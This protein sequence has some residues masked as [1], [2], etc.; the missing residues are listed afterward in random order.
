MLLVVFSSKFRWLDL[1]ESASQYECGAEQIHLKISTA[2]FA[3][4]FRL[5]AIFLVFELELV[6]L[7]LALPLITALDPTPIV[8]LVVFVFLIQIASLVEVRSGAVRWLRSSTTTLVFSSDSPGWV[9][10]NMSIY[11]WCLL[12]LL[13]LWPLIIGILDI[14]IEKIKSVVG[15]DCSAVLGCTGYAVVIFCV[16]AVPVLALPPTALPDVFVFLASDVELDRKFFQR[17]LAVLDSPK[18]NGGSLAQRKTLLRPL[19]RDALAYQA[20]GK[21]GF[22]AAY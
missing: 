13:C 19:M 14:S 8:I 3:S 6:V 12:V 9:T 20:A 7:F 5:L 1:R 4:F 22:W 15:T 2:A 16:V 18:W 11:I 10:I 17:V 21:V